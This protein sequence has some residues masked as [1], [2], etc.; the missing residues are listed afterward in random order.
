MWR[1]FLR[2]R[3]C[4]SEISCGNILFFCP[5]SYFLHFISI[6]LILL[7]IT[8][9]TFN[10]NMWPLSEPKQTYYW[11]LLIAPSWV[12]STHLYVQILDEL[13]FLMIPYRKWFLLTWPHLPSRPT[14]VFWWAPALRMEWWRRG[15]R[16]EGSAGWRMWRR[17]RVWS[18]QRRNCSTWTWVT[19]SS[20][21]RTGQL[22][23]LSLF[24]PNT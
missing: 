23:F 17:R 19:A 10:N 2:T 12:H 15:G 9:F 7:I 11:C 8:H 4:G 20:P 24:R 13:S 18:S 6:V 5:Q 22:I 16:G 1:L 14:G 21:I 3:I